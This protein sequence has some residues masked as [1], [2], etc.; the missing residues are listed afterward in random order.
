MSYRIRNYMR[1]DIVTADVGTSVFEASRIMLEKDI[2][3]LI[4]LDKRKPVGIVTVRD[5]VMEVMAKARDPLKMKI[6]EIMSS[7]LVTID[8]DS[9]VQEAVE[10]M[11]KHGIRTLAVVRDGTL[12]GTFG[13]RDLARHFNEYSEIVTRDII[14]S[15]ARISIPF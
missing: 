2:G 5:L 11:V 4:V 1:E 9:D 3:Y 14:K 7:P 6:S 12:Y 8:P 15:M 10:T 13:A